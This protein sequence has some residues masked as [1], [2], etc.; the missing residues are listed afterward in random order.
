[1]GTDASAALKALHSLLQQLARA[2][3]GLSEGPRRIALAEKQIAQTEQQIEKQKQAIRDARKSA[4]EHNLRLKSKEAE[5]LKLQGQLNTASSNKEYDIIKGQIS[6]ATASRGDIEEQ[7]LMALEA[8]DAANAALRGFESDL[9]ARRKAL[10]M[11][12]Q[13]SVA[14]EIIPASDRENWKRLRAAHGAGCI[15]AVEDEFCTS[16]D[17]KAIAQDL[18]RIR[19][20]VIVFCRGC[21]RVLY[22]DR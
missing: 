6:A 10:Q 8:V 4:D 2:E 18:V 20:G 15:A 5:M 3:A 12:Q 16:C 11:Q 21:G 13:I 7:G 1:M 19:T 14:E 9:Q 17:Q 22:L